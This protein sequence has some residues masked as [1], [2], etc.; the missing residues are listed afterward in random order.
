[1]KQLQKSQPCSMVLRL[2][3]DDYSYNDA[4][5]LALRAYPLTNMVKLEKELDNYI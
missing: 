5:T 2:M 4:L 3:D 1:M